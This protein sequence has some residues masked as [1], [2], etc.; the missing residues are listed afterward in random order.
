MK[1]GLVIFDFDGV[2]VD[3]Q[4][5]VNKIEWEFLS[6]YGA[7]ITLEEYAERFSGITALSTIKMLRKE[8]KLE[9]PKKVD[10]FAEEIDEAVC[11]KLS[12]SKINPMKGMKE[13]LQIFPFPKC[14]A[15][16][17]TLKNLRIFL[18]ASTL[19][20]YFMGNVFSADMV[21]NPK[22]YPDLFLYAA[23]SMGVEPSQC[24]VIEDSEAGIKAAVS[25]GMEAWGFLGG[26]H[27]K[28]GM[29]EK[30]LHSGAKRT[31]TNMTE[32]LPLIEQKNAQNFL[33]RGKKWLRTNFS[34]GE[35]KIKKF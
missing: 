11:E 25:A 17:C 16:N 3:T 20:S 10:L 35:S 5:A 14:V 27:I 33:S 13:L 8:K 29:E 15:S 28:P 22:P 30:I 26:K 23:Q 7:Q 19:A 12:L 1:P 2:L 18:S 24:L 34:Q 9:L 31:F 21:K 6:K 4:A 32:L